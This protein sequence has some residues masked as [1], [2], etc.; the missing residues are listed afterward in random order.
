MS[1]AQH[2]RASVLAD[3]SGSAIGAGLLAVLVS[4]AGPLLIYFSAA[5]AMGVGMEVFTSWV[6]AIS[7]AAGLSSVAL[8]LWLRVP[9]AM[10][11]SA[12]GTVLLISLDGSLTLAEVIGAYFAVALSL[13]AIGFSG[14]FDRLVRLLPPSV[15]NGMMAG[16]LFGFGLKAAAGLATDAG[17]IALLLAVFAIVSVLVPRYAMLALLALALLAM[18]LLSG[19]SGVSD[20]RFLASPKS[21][22]PRSLQPRC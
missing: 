2:P 21:R 6:F 1:E 15:T 12:P 17:V 11:W 18:P 14:V 4:Y 7:I 20:G 5:E 3:L 10:A 19:G 9:V 22:F 8:S 13:V 16:I